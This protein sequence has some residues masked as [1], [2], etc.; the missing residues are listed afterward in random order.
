MLSEKRIKEAESNVN[1]YL[2]E[3]LLKKSDFNKQILDILKKNADESLEVAIFLNKN[4]K[5]SLWIIVVSYYSM[6]YLANALL[7]RL[8]YKVGDKIAHKVTAD[9][10]MIFAREKIKDALIEGYE[11]IRDEALA[12]M[13]SDELIEYFDFE[14]RK[15]SFIQYNTPEEIKI[16]KVKTSLERA[17]EFMF[18]ISKLLEE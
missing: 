12:K 13:K 10:L 18:Q 3:G 16:S 2:K 11:E 1:K 7:Y 14:R 17:K 6:F 9:A 8:G 5:S 4:N 15:R